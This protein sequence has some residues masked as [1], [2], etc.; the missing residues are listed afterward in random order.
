M[1]QVCCL[2]ILVFLMP[3]VFAATPDWQAIF[4]NKDGCFVLYDLKTNQVVTEYNQNR[5]KKRF[6]PCSTFKIAIALMAFDQKILRDATTKIK[7]DGI[8]R[9]FPTWNQDQTPI[10]WLKY[11]TIWVSQWITPQI[12]IVKINQYLKDFAYGN[13]DM[14]GGITSAWL[15]SSLQISAYEQINFLHNLWQD[16]LNVTP[17]AMTLVKSIIPQESTSAGDIIYGKTGAGVQEHK[18]LGWYVGYFIHKNHPFAFATNISY[19]S[20]TKNAKLPGESAK[21]VTKIILQ[22]LRPTS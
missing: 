10:T 14:S 13:Q 16:K 12:G 1:K 5:C 11:S 3:I 9:D 6:A 18:Q 21:E 8:K 15:S 22:S 17:H 4:H 7:W 2:V 19:M 20:P